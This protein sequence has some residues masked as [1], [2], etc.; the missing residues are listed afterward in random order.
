MFPNALNALLSPSNTAPSPGIFE[1]GFV[2][3]SLGGI[4]LN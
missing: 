1:I 3:N 2:P 4:I